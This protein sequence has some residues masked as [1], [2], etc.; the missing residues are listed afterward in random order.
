[1]NKIK[2]IIRGISLIALACVL[3]SVGGVRACGRLAKGAKAAKAAKSADS[4]Y[5]LARAYRATNAMKNAKT[6][7]VFTNALSHVNDVQTLANVFVIDKED[8]SISDINTTLYKSGLGKYFTG[9]ITDTFYV[10]SIHRFQDLNIY[11]PEMYSIYEY[12]NN[13]DVLQLSYGIERIRLSTTMLSSA[14]RNKVVWLTNKN[15]IKYRS[16]S[17]RYQDELLEYSYYVESKKQMYKL[18]FA[19][20]ISKE[21]DIPKYIHRLEA[22]IQLIEDANHITANDSIQP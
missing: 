1:M 2:P 4:A 13:K 8:N 22:L 18:Y 5:D 10:D 20:E 19:R 11:V 6:S 21:E 14:S 3:T 7:D 16:R 9:S 12:Y 15:G 17:Y